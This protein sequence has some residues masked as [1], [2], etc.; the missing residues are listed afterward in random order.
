MQFIQH[1]PD[2]PD[3]LLQA[4]EEGRVVFFC[5]AGISYPAG[6]PGFGSLVRRIYEDIGEQPNAIEQTAIKAGQFDTAI[7]L[8][9][10]RIGSRE[11]VRR[12]VAAILTPNLDARHS[13]STHQALLTLARCRNSRTRLITTNFD[14]LFETVIESKRQSIQ[15]FQA[16]LLPVPKNRWDGL[17]YLHGLLPSKPTSS[18][19]DRLVLSSG[20]FGLAYLTERW[21]ARF[22]SELFRN[23]TVCFVGYS[24]NDPVMRYMMD[25]LAADS[26]LGE[27]PPEMFAFGSY[28]KGKEQKAADEWLAKKVT[29]ILYRE[30]NNHAYLHKTLRA[31]A[32]TYRDGV[33]G[34]ERIVVEYAMTRPMASTR[35]D[36]YVGRML[37][38]L[39][40]DS[41][42]PAKRFANFDPVPSLD[43]LEPLSEGRYNHADLPR[44]GIPPLLKQDDK[45]IFSLIHRPAPYTHAPWM[46]LTDI[47]ANCGWDNVMYHLAQW[48]TR[49]LDDP[50]LVLW[51]AKR[52]GQPHDRLMLLIEDRLDELSRF[53]REG[54]NAELDNIR[55]NAPNAIPQPLM[56]T[57]WR[58][59]LTGRV[60][61][62][63]SDLDL[64]R[65]KDRL[66]RDG[67][68]A[69]LRLDLRELLAPKISLQQPFRWKE[70]HLESGTPKHINDLFDWDLVLTAN[71]VQSSL[72]DLAKSDAW[73]AA[74]PT[75]LEDFQQLLRDAL[76]LKRE[77]GVAD[78]Q[79]DNSHWDLPSIS[80]HRQNTDF[81]DWVAL[82]ELL[83]DAWLTTY[84]SN[85]TQ[86][87]RIALDWFLQPY[88][89]FKRLAL[90]AANYEGVTPTAEWVDWLL[91]DDSWWLWSVET[92]RETM[93]L[94]VQRGH[95]VPGDARERLETAILAGPPRQMYVD[96]I[97][98]ERWQELVDHSMWLHLA[99]LASAGSVMGDVAT[100]KLEELSA[101]HPL[102]KLATNQRDEFSHWM[103]GT[104]D[105]DFE[106]Q[107]EIER[108]PRRRNL[109]VKWL[110]HPPGKRP[111]Y[112]DDWREI[113]RER[114]FVSASALCRL[115][116]ENLWPAER[117]REALQA[118][119]DD[120]HILRS[121]RYLA[122]LLQRMP[123][124]VLLIVAHSASYWMESSSKVMDR[125]EAIFWDICHRMLAMQ[126]QDGMVAKP[127][128]RAI[129]HPVGHI[130]KA[131]LQHWF[132]S[133]PEDDQGLPDEFRIVFTQLCDTNVEQYRHAR[134]LLAARLITLYRVDREWTETY[135]LP[136]FSWQTS[137]VE[138]QGV[139]EGFLWSPRLYRPL[140]M[141]F[142][143]NFLETAQHYTELGEHGGQF[144]SILTYIALDPADTYTTAELYAAMNTL[145]Q[146]GLQESAQT[147]VNALE[148][149]EEQREE[150][151]TNRV[152]PFWQKIWPKSRQMISPSISEKLA[153]LAIAAR[154]AFPEA[155]ATV[156]N[157]LQPIEHPN[158]TIHRL[159]ESGLCSQFP[160]EAI[161]LLDAII[162]D[163]RW[164]PR[165]IGDCLKAIAQTWQD[166]SND[167]RYQRL[168][169]YARRNG[170]G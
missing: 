3:R 12:T 90:F 72:N 144:A 58:F 77:L 37:W 145:P 101:A 155:L 127:V 29:P 95:D 81:H 61:S 97:E 121:W 80:P 130:T 103:S 122:P 139:W 100:A 42:L 52:G 89:T 78:E 66:D 167:H 152:Q 71:H 79:I 114:F 32:A 156:R 10:A 69:T 5:G 128:M 62:S 17:V 1:G 106:D 20:D 105:P 55:S 39:S 123:D 13:T 157:Y 92:K 170:L 24:I 84:E 138:A 125:H 159:N 47:G 83:R 154:G 111:F 22:I 35:Q 70:V 88:P 116:D 120:Q 91:A 26:L 117:W 136:L 43:W 48:L 87:I 2:I 93:R 14:R 54:K 53:E 50:M 4:Q 67:L 118:W 132:T 31:W 108:A 63:L 96:D 104:G 160:R 126:H 74:L 7:G 124:D 51:L 38:A 41:G 165:E 115:A 140:F 135:L 110:Q 99:K 163:Q 59:L 18:E 9:E 143:N 49:H 45:L 146:K 158:Y 21:A 131:L 16:P 46:M 113:C 15:C 57:V 34:K 142:K 153:R 11:A 129:N 119:S 75:L 8:L 44:F 141:A 109:L 162:D 73:R 151:W 148:G 166:A 68:S 33:Q 147:L 149:S 164:A 76:N 137:A 168:Q 64:F 56:R 86:A 36:D 82:I 40:H 133:Q 102:W 65:W 19:L 28:S 107:K 98:P 85:S 60:K 6:L 94:L 27:S 30:H 134:V 169:E 25:A 112:E 23:F 150:Y 161:T